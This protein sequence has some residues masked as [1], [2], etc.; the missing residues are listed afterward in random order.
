M[1]NNNRSNLIRKKYIKLFAAYFAV[2]KVVFLRK[3]LPDTKVLTIYN[4]L[5]KWL[6]AK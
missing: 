5:V 1:L 4:Q 2:N 3:L 6:E